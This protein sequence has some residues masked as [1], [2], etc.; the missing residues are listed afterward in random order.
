MI[1]FRNIKIC[2]LF[3]TFYIFRLITVTKYA[4]VVI[5]TITG[6]IVYMGN[7]I[8]GPKI[9]YYYNRVIYQ[10]LND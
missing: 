7:D 8:N 6:K 3:K 5:G 4:L 2:Y 9:N 10:A 1:G